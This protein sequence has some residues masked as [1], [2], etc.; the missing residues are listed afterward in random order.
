[1]IGFALL[2][3][4]LLGF[5]YMTLASSS[6]NRKT[7]L[8]VAGTNAISAQMAV[9]TSAATDNRILGHGNAK[10]FVWYLRTL[11]GIVGANPTYPIRVQLDAG[12]GILVYEFPI[13][14]PGAVTGEVTNVNTS[15]QQGQYDLARGV[16]FVYLR[17][18][19]V[20]ADFYEWNDLQAT[21]GG[22]TATPSGNTFFDM[23]GD[24]LGTGIFTDLI[25]G[26]TSSFSSSGLSS[27][28]VSVSIMYYSRRQ[29]LE[30]AQNYA[31]SV[32]AGSFPDTSYTN[33]SVTRNYIISDSSILGL[34]VY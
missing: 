5:S 21:G 26:P 6:L 11:Q 25:T 31:H 23:D 29:D 18:N 13:A 3:P 30:D 8:L 14:A 28:P 33:V 7:E 27:L 2:I 16:M 20:P 10:G 9:M 12:Q 19:S 17:E 24:G 1:M 34:G 15:V 32:R 4:I 22:E